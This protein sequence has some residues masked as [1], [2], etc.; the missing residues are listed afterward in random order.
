MR[1]IHAAPALALL[2][3]WFTEGITAAQTAAEKP[4]PDHTAPR[5]ENN[6]LI[7][8]FI[9]EFGG[10]GDEP[11][12]FH[13][14]IGIAINAQD[15]LFITEFH[16]HRVQKFTA[17]GRW[18]AA[19]PVVEHPG[20]I[21][22]DRAGH[23]FVAALLGHKIAV[24]DAD[25]RRLREWGKKG[26]GDGEFNEPGGLVIESDGSLLVADQ[27]NHR[28]QRFTPDG[29]FLG[30]WG[31]YGNDAGQ[32]GGKGRQGMRFG[33]PH[34]AALD[35]GG[36]I[37]TTEGANGRIQQF[38]K[39]GSPLLHWGSNTTAPG[40]FGGREKAAHN[41]LPGPIAVVLDAQQRVWVSA[42]NDR[43]Q[44]FT[45][46]GEFLGGL[47][48]A[49]GEPGKLRLPHGMAFDSKGFLYV[50]DS[51]NHRVQKFKP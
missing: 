19:F 48:E 15:E 44:V 11:G 5:A 10:K 43:V 20:G 33:G 50:V 2:T 6:W 30:K 38:T 34:F 12:K 32:F 21:A 17:E 29:R 37:W 7:P 24:Y 18:L 35:A 8:Q 49:G 47:M 31:S 27:C 26:A 22:V 3:L 16:T 28:M 40:G 9:L 1:P 45:K 25:G 14:P 4:R 42:S 51:S 23:L 46:T 36:L 13:S 41:A 39:D